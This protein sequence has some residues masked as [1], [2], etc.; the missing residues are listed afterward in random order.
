M[1]Y[2]YAGRILRVDLSS[3]LIEEDKLPNEKI[4]REYIGC[5]GPVGLGL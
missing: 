3:G 1:S 2:G 4:L 5:R